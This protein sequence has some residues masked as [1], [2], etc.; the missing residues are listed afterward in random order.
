MNFNISEWRRQM[1]RVKSVFRSKRLHIIPEEAQEDEDEEAKPGNSGEDSD[2][3]S[4][5]VRDPKTQ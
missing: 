1:I 2:E 4:D 3:F 5:D